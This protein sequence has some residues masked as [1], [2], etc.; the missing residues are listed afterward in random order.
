[1]KAGSSHTM[2]KTTPVIRGSSPTRV[3]NG[4]M[5]LSGSLDLPPSSCLAGGLRLGVEQ[6]PWVESPFHSTM[7][8]VPQRHP[9]WGS[10]CL[11]LSFRGI[12]EAHEASEAAVAGPDSGFKREQSSYFVTRCHKYLQL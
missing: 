5:K 6:G 11:L 3:S 1:M 2:P 9:Y 12:D 8:W 10:F 4:S 7:T